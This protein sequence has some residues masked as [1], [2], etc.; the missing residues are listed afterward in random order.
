[1]ARRST[2]LPKLR[3]SPQTLQVDLHN[4]NSAL[5]HLTQLFVP[6]VYYI[7]SGLYIQPISSIPVIQVDFSSYFAMLAA[8][9]FVTMSLGLFRIPLGGI[10]RLIRLI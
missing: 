3:I 6:W 1:M 5:V 9:A 7:T 4:I 2:R 10:D 8:F